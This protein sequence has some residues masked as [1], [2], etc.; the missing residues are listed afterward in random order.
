MKRLMATLELLEK[1]NADDPTEHLSAQ[2][3][4]RNATSTPS[5][6]EHAHI[7]HHVNVFN[8]V[9]ANIKLETIEKYYLECWN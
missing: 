6:D 7:P 5:V 1:S 8:A 3:P 4:L 9:N 2:I